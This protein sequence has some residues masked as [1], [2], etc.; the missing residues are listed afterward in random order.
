MIDAGV[1]SAG[2]GAGIM[3]LA[4]LTQ[5]LISNWGWA[6]ALQILSAVVAFLLLPL[7]WVFYRRG[8]YGERTAGRHQPANHMDRKAGV[9]KPS[10]LVSL[11]RSDHGRQRYHGNRYSSSGPM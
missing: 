11:S 8:P 6:A 5:W 10:V 9:A 1:V 2:T 4:P 7:V 3:L